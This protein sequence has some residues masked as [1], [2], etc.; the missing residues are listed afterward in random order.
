M[1]LH[2]RYP[3]LILTIKKNIILTGLLEAKGYKVVSENGVKKRVEIDAS[4][5]NPDNFVPNG[6]SST[7]MTTGVEL[8]VYIPDNEDTNKG[9][10]FGSADEETPVMKSIATRVDWIVGWVFLGV[11]IIGGN[12]RLGHHVAMKSLIVDI[13][14]MKL[15]IQWR[16]I[17]LIDMM[18]PGMNLKRLVF[19]LVFILTQVYK[20]PKCLNFIFFR[21]FSSC[22]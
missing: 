16:S 8:L 7:G 1:P 2:D 10:A 18:F 20:I 3:P 19:Y 17:L 13:V 22:E 4:L 21:F 12:A 11:H 5:H 14:T 15:R 9:R 6:V